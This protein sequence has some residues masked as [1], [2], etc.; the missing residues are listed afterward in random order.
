MSEEEIAEYHKCYKDPIYFIENYVKTKHGKP[1]KLWENQKRLIIAQQ[2]NKVIVNK[3][4][5]DVGTS[6]VLGFLIAHYMC[7]N[8][9]HSEPV[10]V[11]FLSINQNMSHFMCSKVKDIINELPEFI[12][13]K[14]NI[15]FSNKFRLTLPNGSRLQCK[16]TTI[17][18]LKG[19]NPT[20]VIFDFFNHQKDNERIL[21]MITSNFC[22]DN[23]IT[24]TSTPGP[25]SDLY[26]KFF[27]EEE[28]AL[29]GGTPICRLA[30][31]WQDN[32]NHRTMM[33][34][35]RYGTKI[36]PSNW[37]SINRN[38]EENGFTLKNV[39]LSKYCDNITSLQFHQEIMGE[40]LTDED[41]A[42]LEPKPPQK[43]T[44][45][46]TGGLLPFHY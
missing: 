23:K 39:W 27:R 5:R 16:T 31:N 37:L 25:Y 14:T 11:C 1:I 36:P 44:R 17:D 8:Q 22:G 24:L 19:F 7:F 29:I 10:S 12:L 20:W 33:Y 35:G 2:T 3:E 13:N 28:P 9:N 41:K 42:F 4:V 45:N 38:I 30:E 21:S 40:L 34:V 18:A 46:S 6:D 26:L 32:P 43:K 15:D